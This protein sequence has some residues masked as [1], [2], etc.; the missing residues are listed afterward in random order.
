MKKAL[1]IVAMLLLVTPVMATTTITAV[2][3]SQFT[4]PD[5]NK[6][7]IVRISYS[8]V[9]GVDPCYVRAFALDINID[10]N[11]TFANIRDFNTGEANGTSKHSGYGIFPG[12]F[13]DFVNP[14][15]PGPNYVDANNY[16]PTTAWDEPETTDHN[17]GMGWHK[18]IVEMGTLYYGDA[19]RPAITGTL[20]RFDVNSNGSVGTFHLAV[21][22]NAL[23]GG[24]VSGDGNTITPVSAGTDI[25]FTAPCTTPTYEVGQQRSAAEAVWVGQGFTGGFNA[26]A[27]PYSDTIPANQVTIQDTGCY[28]LS[29]TINYT[30]S[31]GRF[32]APVTLKYPPYDSDCNVPVYWS[33]VT[34]A[35]KYI[36]Q[37][38]HD[39]GVNWT[40][41]YTG[42]G[43]YKLDTNTPGWYRYRV[44]AANADSNSNWTTGTVDA[45]VYLSTCYKT[46]ADPNYAEW[47]KVGRPDCWCKA[48]TAQEPNGSGYQCDGDA[49]GAKVSGSG[50]RVFTADSTI[51]ANAWKKKSSDM[52]A[53]PNVTL[54]GKLKICL[55][56]A[57]FDHKASSGSAY[58]VYSNDA[59][60]LSSHWKFKDS[61]V[62]SGNTLPG[63]CPR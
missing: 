31:K 34:G 21:K 39:K 30:Y 59:A 51:M 41:V 13:R 42:T 52:Q 48:S 36:V 9:A 26:T 6:V 1:L 44:L 62:T 18:M 45:N 23:R 29:Y 55:A 7:Q 50:Y 22:P 20:F 33:A 10:G 5:G 56:C 63:N 25:T 3:E 16:N 8:S 37:S 17:S 11:S 12:R 24:V 14:T 57:D 15:N 2:P 40:A 28:A 27:G 60:I 46:S 38:S 53:D 43:T 54:A 19:N 32:P 61:S 49:D 4:A 35:T 47:V 58:R